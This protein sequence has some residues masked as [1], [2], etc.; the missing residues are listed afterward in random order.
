MR[1]PDV[2][3]V[4]LDLAQLRADAHFSIIVDGTREAEAGRDDALVPL[5]EAA[6]AARLLGHDAARIALVGHGVDLV[7]A[8]HHVSAVDVQPRSIE[9]GRDRI[10]EQRRAHRCD[11]A[12]LR[13]HAGRGE[14][15]DQ[16]PAK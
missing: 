10:Q 7:Q 4:D 2:Q 1:R 5:A 3:R 15:H 6:D 12:Q 8:L 16:M 9:A 11:A 14:A 13:M